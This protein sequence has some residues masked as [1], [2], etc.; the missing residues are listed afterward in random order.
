MRKGEVL[1]IA[2]VA[3]NGQDEL[4]LALSG[5]LR[6]APDAVRIDGRRCG[7]IGPERA[8][9]RRAWS[10]RPRNGWAM[11]RHRT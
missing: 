4:L 1:G 5:E 2:G 8:A 10:R 3:G 7:D 9:A 11:R 6:P